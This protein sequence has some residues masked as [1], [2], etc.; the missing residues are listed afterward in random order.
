MIKINIKS[1]PYSLYITAFLALSASF[2]PL[3]GKS[4]RITPAASNTKQNVTAKSLL[5]RVYTE[6]QK[7]RQVKV[8][9]MTSYSSG[10]SNENP[11]KDKGTLWL[12]QNKNQYRIDLKDQSYISDG[13]SQWIVLND[14]KEVQITEVSDQTGQISPANMFSFFQKGFTQKLV[15][16]QTVAGKNL[17]VIELVPEKKNQ[18]YQKIILRISKADNQI[19]DILVFDKNN[20]RLTYSIERIQ[21]LETVDAGLFKFNPK[22]YSGFE[23]VDLR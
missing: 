4:L 12:V 11:V 9:F 1:I 21:T 14:I 18:S 22:D 5:D 2:T 13:A 19:A 7:K 16:S 23:I 6:Y 3:S 10:R 8:G 17:W 15:E 20:G